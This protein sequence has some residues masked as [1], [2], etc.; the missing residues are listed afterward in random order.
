[1]DN[2]DEVIKRQ[3]GPVE[4]LD[5]CLSTFAYTFEALVSIPATTSSLKP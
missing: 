1:M 4:W 3:T 2:V 5:G